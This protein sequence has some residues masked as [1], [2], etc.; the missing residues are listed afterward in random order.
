MRLI[1]PNC[2]AQYEVDE[3]VIPPEGRDVQCANCGHN[4]FQDSL[5]ML[6]TEAAD[7][8]KNGDP[9]SDVPAELFNDLEGRLE[10]QFVSTRTKTPPEPDNIQPQVASDDFKVERAPALPS[11]KLDQEALDMMRA[12]AEYSSGEKPPASTQEETTEPEP[13]PKVKEEPVET[14]EA[15]PVVPV[16]KPTKA[17]A[18]NNDLDEIRRRIMEMESHES[19]PASVQQAEELTQPL[20][21]E[22]LPEPTEMP[23]VPEV[24]NAPPEEPVRAQPVLDSDNPFSRPARRQRQNANRTES[25]Y[26]ENIPQ[27]EPVEYVANDPVDDAAIEAI[28]NPDEAATPSDTQFRKYSSASNSDKQDDLYGVSKDRKIP[29]K[30]MLPDID[31]LSSEIAQEAEQTTYVHQPVEDKSQKAKTGFFKGFV[32]ALFLYGLIAV[33]Y[34]QKD[35]IVEY[36]PQAEGVLNILSTAV[37]KG[38]MMLSPIVDM[39]KQF[40][41]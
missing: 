7:I 4:W 41:G 9:D 10:S 36:V 37:E 22:H 31:V 19:A 11:S 1:C 12:E 24:V 40:I 39:I 27:E 21:Q 32:Y 8:S 23:I 6:S 18:V 16:E 25:Q 20:G 29:R 13:E 26:E 30:D 35:L 14:V 3:D 34:L 28:A 17:D 2:V 15:P 38:A 33:I 5:K